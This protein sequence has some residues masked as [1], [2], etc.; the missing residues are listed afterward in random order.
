MQS[1]PHTDLP[2]SR[3]SFAQAAALGALGV[4][5][6]GADLRKACAQEG[7]DDAGDDAAEADDSG[8]IEAGGFTLLPYT[9]YA[10]GGVASDLYAVVLFENSNSTFT[11]Y[12]V[13]YTS[14]TCRDAASNYR[15]VVYVELLNTKDTADEAAIRSI[16]FDQNGGVN[17]GL[18][19]DSCP[20]H[21]R[22]DYDEAY[23]DEHLVQP[24]VGTTKADV[25]AWSGYGDFVDA[26]DVDA[27][28]GATVSTSN[29]TSLLQALFAYHARKY[30]AA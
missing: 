24:L 21:D 6:L 19:G 14:C 20:I 22:P 3:R 28:A 11:R 9:H 1:A 8:V 30:Y 25:D 4:L 13:A 2:V 5:G 7:P 16:S 23:M 17:V 10:S 26:L 27:V 29:L 15:S 12:Q 18:W